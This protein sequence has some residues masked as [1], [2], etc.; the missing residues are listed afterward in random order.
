MRTDVERAR[1]IAMRGALWMETRGFGRRGRSVYSLIKDEFGLKGN[2][3][4][5]YT[6]F[7]GLCV[8]EGLESRPLQ[9]DR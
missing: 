4:K 9:V 2:K 8:S 7:D 1:M 6:L 3:R 5:V